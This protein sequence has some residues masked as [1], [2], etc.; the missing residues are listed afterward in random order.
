MLLKSYTWYSALFGSTKRSYF[1]ASIKHSFIQHLVKTTYESNKRCRSEINF[2]FQD[3]QKQICTQVDVTV[4]GTNVSSGWRGMQRAGLWPHDL[5]H[6]HS[7][8][9]RLLTQP[10]KS[11][12]NWKNRTKTSGPCS[13]IE[14]AWHNFPSLIPSLC[15]DRSCL[16]EK[17]TKQESEPTLRRKWKNFNQGPATWT[18]KTRTLAK[19]KFNTVINCHEV[20]IHQVQGH[21]AFT[22]TTYWYHRVLTNASTPG[23]THSFSLAACPQFTTRLT[24]EQSSDIRQTGIEP[25][26]YHFPTVGHETNPTATNGHIIKSPV[27]RAQLP[28]QGVTTADICEHVTY[29]SPPVPGEGL[30]SRPV[31]WESQV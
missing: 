30:S 21:E 31:G 2:Y 7:T 23:D 5:Q 4:T 28:S 8:Q 14:T 17:R 29:L 13:E 27:S 24:R 16:G 1:V 12:V 10:V 15:R 3:S 9:P 18:S 25:Q 20:W 22:N 26:L 6:H 11:G 19:V